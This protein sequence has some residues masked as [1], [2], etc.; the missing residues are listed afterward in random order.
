MAGDVVPTGRIL[1]G[2]R[3]LV[4]GVT[5]DT[6]IGFH[7]AKV[8]QQQGAEVA[9]TNFGRALSITRRI[10]GRLQSRA[11]EAIALQVHR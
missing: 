8:A 5:M 9:I 7:V 10:A 3:I 4:A 1:E 6:S 11:T 2:K